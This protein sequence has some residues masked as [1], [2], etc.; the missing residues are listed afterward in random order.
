MTPQAAATVAS[1][2]CQF[3]LKGVL[4]TYRRGNASIT[5]LQLI[6]TKPTHVEY[7]DEETSTSSREWDFLVLREQFTLD[8]ERLLPEEH[9]VIEWESA[10]GTRRTAEVLIRENDRVYRPT[11]DAFV[12]LRIYTVE[13][14]PLTEAANES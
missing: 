4:G 3:A 1:H 13:T 8:G 9:D 7:G 12:Q 6:P 2:N 5:G 10:D 11:N 14:E